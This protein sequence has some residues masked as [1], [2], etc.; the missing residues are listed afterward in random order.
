MVDKSSDL[1]FAKTSSFEE[2]TRSACRNNV[3][4]LI[5]NVPKNMAIHNTMHSGMQVIRNRIF[6]KSNWQHCIVTL[7]DR[8]SCPSATK[9]RSYDQARCLCLGSGPTFILGRVDLRISI[10]RCR[11]SYSLLRRVC[12]RWC[13]GGEAPYIEVAILIIFGETFLKRV[14]DEQNNDWENLSNIFLWLASSRFLWML[15]YF[16]SYYHVTR[17]LVWPLMP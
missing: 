4:L 9:E 2:F 13:C 14:L 6:H 16:V 3:E 5:G 7:Q 10:S 12:G 8:V 1:L 15:V 17:P 11:I